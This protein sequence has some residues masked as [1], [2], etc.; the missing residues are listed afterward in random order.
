MPIE[1]VE[2]SSGPDDYRERK[3]KK[4]RKAQQPAPEPKNKPKK[5][6]F[7]N[8]VPN[9]IPGLEGT[10]ILLV[11]TFNLTNLIDAPKNSFF[12][13]KIVRDLVWV[14]NSPFIL[15]NLPQLPD[16]VVDSTEEKK[17][18]Y[19]TDLPLVPDAWNAVVN[20]AKFLQELDENPQEFY[21]W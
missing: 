15:R 7:V 11:T 9:P 2:E 5:R 17:P 8:L 1:G 12:R 21:D 19:F 18:D 4:V 14:M 16:F 13:Q 20:D 3:A 6:V 10:V